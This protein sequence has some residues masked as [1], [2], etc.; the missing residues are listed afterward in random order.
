MISIVPTGIVF[1]EKS[2]TYFSTM[3]LELKIKLKSLRFNQNFTTEFKQF[4]TLYR[5]KWLSKCCLNELQ[6]SKRLTRRLA[7]FGAHTTI[8]LKTE[9]CRR[10]IRSS[11]KLWLKVRRLLHAIDEAHKPKLVK[12]FHFKHTSELSN[13]EMAK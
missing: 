12:Q 7:N 13:I 5:N 3:I 2:K 1:W 11:N 6:P 4:Y 10:K 9:L 8:L